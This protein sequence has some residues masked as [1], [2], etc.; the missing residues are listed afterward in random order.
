MLSRVDNADA[1][2]DHRPFRRRG[3]VRRTAL[4]PIALA[5][6]FAVYP[7]AGA[8]YGPDFVAAVVVAAI[9]VPL[10]LL[11][12]WDRLPQAAQIVP[13]L[14]Y[15]ASVMLL[16]EAHGGASS[17]Y[18]PWAFVPVIW[19]ALYGVWWQLAAMIA[20]VGIGL[21]LPILVVG[22]PQYPD[23][24]WQRVAGVLFVSAALGWT[25]KSLVARLVEQTSA[26]VGAE[27]RVRELEAFELHDDVVQSLTEAQL[28]LALERP[29]QAEPAVRR[30]LDT[31]QRLVERTL[32]ESPERFAPGRL[33]RE[34]TPRRADRG[35]VA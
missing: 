23:A 30:A 22:E 12:P 21:A 7:F 10:T 29:G 24:E 5:L 16:R 27:R 8:A 11:T 17:G 15:L 13:P 20:F 34:S 4:F 28:A 19:V 32:G 14:L 3:L 26:R 1:V 35:P 18:A 33:A 25:I 31:A 9:S 2:L 6:A